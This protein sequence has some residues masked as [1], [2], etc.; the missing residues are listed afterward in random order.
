MKVN[1]QHTDRAH[2][3]V[4]VFQRLG[5]AGKVFNG[6]RLGQSL[7]DMAASTTAHLCNVHRSPDGRTPGDQLDGAITFFHGHHHRSNVGVEGFLSDED[8]TSFCHVGQ[9]FVGEGVNKD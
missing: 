6:H 7:S 9:L 3:P 2:A 5:L 4:L 1:A 8:D